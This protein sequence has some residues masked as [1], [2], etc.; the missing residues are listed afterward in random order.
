MGPRVGPMTA[1]L[2]FFAVIGPLDGPMTAP[3]IDTRQGQKM[4]PGSKDEEND[5]VSDVI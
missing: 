3:M 5:G 4:E 2:P 1:F